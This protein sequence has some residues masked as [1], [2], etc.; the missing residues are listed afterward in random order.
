MR[1]TTDELRSASALS[2]PSNAVALRRV[3]VLLA[4][5]MG[6]LVLAGLTAIPIQWEIDWLARLLGADRPDASTGVVRWVAELRVGV[7]EGYGRYPFLAYGTDWLAFGHFVIALAFIGPWRDPIRNVWVIEWG[8]WACVLVF[9]MALIFGP[10][11]DIPLAHRLIDCS[12]GLFGGLPLWVALRTVRQMEVE[13]IGD[14]TRTR[15]SLLR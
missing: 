3:R 7:D 6:G 14:Q 4:V 9:P 10:L 11:R 12:F 5:V 1:P 15:S 13:G 8:M 2:L